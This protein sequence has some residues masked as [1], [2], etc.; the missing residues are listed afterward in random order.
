MKIL[1]GLS[2]RLSSQRLFELGCGN[3]V[4]AH[5][6]ASHGW[7]VV[8]VDPSIGGI[9]QGN[10]NFPN[11][12]LYIGSSDDG[13]AT[14]YGKFPV[15]LSLEV[16]EH[17]YNPRKY[18]ACVYSLLEEGGVAIISTPYHSY[19]K[20]LVLALTGKMDAHFTALWD[21]GHIK[22]WS[23]ATLNCLLKEVGFKSV[24]YRLVGRIP[25]LAKS[26]IAIA[27]K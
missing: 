7:S 18:A 27:R 19:I 4:V 12:P 26:M 21:F 13:L 15:V 20:N 1:S 2:Q 8:G 22:F 6:V 11:I 17:V 14:L 23:M 24:E 5:L 3:G 10:Q 16:I 25:C 9:Q